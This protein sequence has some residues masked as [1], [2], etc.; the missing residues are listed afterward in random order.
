VPAWRQRLADET[1]PLWF[2][3]VIEEYVLDRIVGGPQIVRAQPEHLLAPDEA[4]QRGATLVP[5]TVAVHDGGF[6]LLDFDEA[7][8]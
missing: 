6:L 8:H 5:V 1:D 4:R 2:R 3:A 7:Q